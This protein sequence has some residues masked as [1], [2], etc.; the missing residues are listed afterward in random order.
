[1]PAMRQRPVTTELAF[2]RKVE[3]LAAFAADAVSPF[4]DRSP[5]DREHRLARA[6]EDY[7]FFAATY[8]PHYFEDDSPGFHHELIELAELEPDLAAGL[9]LLCSAT[10]APRGFAKSTLLC[11]GYVL[12][13][14]LRRKRRLNFAVLG[15][16]TASLAEDHVASLGAELT[17]NRRIIYDYR[18]QI[19]RLKEGD[20]ILKDGG[21]VLA[22][23]AGQQVRGVKHRAKRPELVILD[24]LEN[25]D[26]ARNPKRVEKILRWVLGT[27]LGAFGKTGTLMV[28]GTILDLKS[29]LATMINSP[30]EPWTHWRRRTY[31]ALLPD[32]TSLWPQRHP[33]E[34]LNAQRLAMGSVQFEREKQNNPRSDEGLFQPEWIRHYSPADLYSKS[35]TVASF[36]DPS[37]GSGESHDYKAV[38]TVGL[39]QDAQIYYVLD[40]FIRKCTLDALTLAVLNRH[41][42]FGPLVFG[43]ED[44]LFQRLLLNEFARA[45]RAAK[46]TLPLRGVTHKLP[47]ET[48]VSGLSPLVERGVI[49]FNPKQGDQ[50]VLIE[51]LLFFP[52]ANVHDDGPDALEGAVRLLRLSGLDVS[53]ESLGKRRTAGLGRGAW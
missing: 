29:A 4:Q 2:D 7:F 19:A 42:E 8:L 12:W 23:G 46:L 27:V 36:V 10:A 14:L 16:E 35:L 15:S 45:A 26:G 48:R 49:R 24:D 1:M 37:V 53:Y 13:R 40:A 43:V 25:D 22:R 33:V 17:S 44:N 28:I 31:R 47:K 21:R 3:A 39:D 9:A 18:P 32:G 6:D 52:S 50:G 20:L 34:L 30:E 38:I 51:Q 11:L 41:R 5:A